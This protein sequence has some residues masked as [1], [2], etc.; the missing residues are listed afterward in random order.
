MKKINLGA[1]LGQAQPSW[2]VAWWFSK[3]AILG[4]GIDPKASIGPTQLGKQLNI[5]GNIQGNSL[6]TETHLE[7]ETEVRCKGTDSDSRA[8]E[9]KDLLRDKEDLIGYLTCQLKRKKVM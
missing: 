7:S 1:E 8:F 6:E 2:S 4:L 3:S 5:Q 9:I